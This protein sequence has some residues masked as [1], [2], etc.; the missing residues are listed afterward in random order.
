MN[1]KPE[2]KFSC[3]AAPQALSNHDGKE[4]Q[5]NGCYSIQITINSTSF[6]HIVI[7]IENLQV[8]CILGMD[9]L[10]K[11]VISIDTATNKIRLGKSKLAKG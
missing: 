10:S 2:E 5:N 7:F 9:F 6:W 4:L 8:P 11:A 3:F 1:S